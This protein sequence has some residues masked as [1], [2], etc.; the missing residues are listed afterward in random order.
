MKKYLDFFMI[1]RMEKN[2]PNAFE[3]RPQDDFLHE[4]GIK[5]PTNA[6]KA[7]LT[8]LIAKLYRTKLAKL[9]R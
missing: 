8:R 6:T 1:N 9:R 2:Q 4:I 5:N 7:R 3:E